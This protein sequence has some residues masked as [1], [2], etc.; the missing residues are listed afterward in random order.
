MNKFR[1]FFEKWFQDGTLIPA[2]DIKCFGIYHFL[3]IILIVSAIIVTAILLKNKEDKIKDTIL[4][5]L[6]ICF[7]V[8]YVLDILFIT[9]IMDGVDNTIN[10]DKLP[11][12]FC[13]FTGVLA[14]FVQFNKK[15][16]FAKLAVVSMAI[17]APMMYLTYPGTALGGY[18]FFCYRVRQ[19]FFYHGCV[20]AWGCLNVAWERVDMS[21]KKIWQPL[22]LLLV[23]VA[24]AFL[25]NSIYNV[26]GIYNYGGPHNHYDWAFI[27]GSFIPSIPNW[28]MPF[29]VIAAVFGVTSLVYLI[30]FIVVRLTRRLINA[31]KK[32]VKMHS[33]KICSLQDVS[34]YGQCSLTVALPILSAYG[35]ETAILPSA[36]L[37][38]HTSGFKDFTVLDLSNELPKII[39][40]WKKENITFD[41]LYTGYIGSK[42]QFDYV[43]DVKENLVKE[44]GYLFVDPAMADHG[45]LYPALD[46]SIIEGMKRICAKADY[47]LPNITEACFLTNNE[48]KEEYDETYINKLITD[49]YSLG[50]KHVILTGVSLEKG[51]LGAIFFDGINTYSYFNTWLPKSY[52]GTGDI[53][54]S[55]MIANI[56]N[57][58]QPE[59]CLKN[60]VD[61]IIDC[62]NSTVDDDTHSYGVKFEQVLFN[63]K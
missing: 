39:N 61:F 50:A 40:H 1:A 19:T 52:H 63:N 4:N 18:N 45:K 24:W 37:S 29:G 11:F 13:T 57:G 58:K 22:V 60:S 27:T 62:I 23:N 2:C 33:M 35:I 43:L 46:E 41:A 6:V 34:C 42:E 32:L 30:R 55:V 26:D 28:L 9:P 12:H 10:M 14:V 7:T 53:F 56:L 48:Y 5:V 54:S 51:K 3:Y 15:F 44:N 31:T 20:M 49:L 21:F 36:I 17:V 38:T 59:E 25:G 16:N 47:I 8:S